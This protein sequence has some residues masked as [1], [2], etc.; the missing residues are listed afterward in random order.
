MAYLCRLVCPPG[1]LVLDPFGG[2][3]TTAVACEQEGFRSILCEQDPEYA[4][5]IQ[6]RIQDAQGADPV[7]PARRKPK[8]PEPQRTLFDLA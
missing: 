5:I 3:G 8:E 2:S 1:G 4:Q 6:A 7:T